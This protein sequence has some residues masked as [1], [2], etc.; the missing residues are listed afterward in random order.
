M[1]GKSEVVVVAVE[2][3]LV[4]CSSREL[5]HCLQFQSCSLDEIVEAHGRHV[6]QSVLAASVAAA[7]IDT[8]NVSLSK[9]LPVKPIMA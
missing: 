8:L 3:C 7:F 5:V 9:A 6:Q 2:L 4:S 1:G